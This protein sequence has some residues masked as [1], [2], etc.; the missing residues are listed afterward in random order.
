MIINLSKLI[1]KVHNLCNSINKIVSINSFLPRLA[2]VNSK[3]MKKI[4]IRF[5]FKRSSSRMTKECTITLVPS[6]IHH[7]NHKIQNLVCQKLIT[8]FKKS[9]KVN[10]IISLGNTI[11]VAM[12]LIKAPIKIK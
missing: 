3:R 7:N 1:K 6:H 2:N 9:M 8:H 11:T 12:I 5:P 10:S 4:K